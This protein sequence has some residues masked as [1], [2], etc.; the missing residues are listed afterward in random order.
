M[1]FLTYDGFPIVLQL[2]FLGESFRYYSVLDLYFFLVL[3]L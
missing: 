3:A 2:I 1:V